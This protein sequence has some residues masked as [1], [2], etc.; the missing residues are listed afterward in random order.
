MDVKMASREAL[1]GAL[2]AQN[3]ALERWS[4]FG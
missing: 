2:R 1:P 3:L 4:A